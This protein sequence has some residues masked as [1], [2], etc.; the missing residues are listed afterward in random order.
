MSSKILRNKV[1]KERKTALNSY[2]LPILYDFSKIYRENEVSIAKRD[3]CYG[4][5]IIALTAVLF[6]ISK[7]VTEC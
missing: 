6:M 4:N 7:D 1:K 3:L 5:D 2:F